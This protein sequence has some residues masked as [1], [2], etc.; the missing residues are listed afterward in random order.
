[1]IQ[2][3]LVNTLDSKN[4]IDEKIKEISDTVGNEIV[5]NALSGG[6]DSSVV[7]VLG[8]RALKEKLRTVFIQN[9]LMREGESEHIQKVFAK[10]GIPVE[11]IDAEDEFFKAL[12]GITD[13]EE[14]RARRKNPQRY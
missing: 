4:F 14:K 1:M 10:M 6:V 9:G 2:E 12:H 13:P 7:T 3:I 5:I 11:V 8:H